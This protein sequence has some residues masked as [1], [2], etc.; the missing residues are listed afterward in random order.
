M[1]N[2]V[3]SG[4]YSPY[5][6]MFHFKDGLYI[7]AV[8]GFL[9]PLKVIISPEYIEEYEVIGEEIRT[10]ATSA[11]GRAAVGAAL[12]GPVGIAAALTAKKKGIYTIGIKWK[13]GKKSIL[14]LD[15]TLYKEF[16]KIMF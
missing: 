14:E 12:L 1:K 2:Y 4:D 5:S 10:S 7:R 15:N 16:V 9:K 3:S 11:V 6:V 8:Q 13:D